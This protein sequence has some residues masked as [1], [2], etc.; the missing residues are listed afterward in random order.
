MHT[1]MCH[2]ELLSVRAVIKV[3]QPILPESLALREWL[4]VEF[5]RRGRIFA[6]GE[7]LTTN[8]RSGGTSRGC[9]S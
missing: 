5:S 6:L 2:V 7:P 4:E 3:L 9:D 1:D 8:T